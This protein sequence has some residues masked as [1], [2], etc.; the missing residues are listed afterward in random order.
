MKL[1]EIL[2]SLSVLAVLV[3]VPAL[4]AFQGQRAIASQTDGADATLTL[5]GVAKDGAWT[6]SK[7]NGTNYWWKSFDP[8]TL[9][10]QEGQ[11]VALRLQSTDVHHRFYAPSL[12]I[13]PVDVEPGHTEI[14]RFRA[15]KPGTY[16]YHCTSI[17]GETHFYMS[18]MIVVSPKGQQAEAVDEQVLAAVARYPRDL[19]EPPKENM[20]EW[21]RYLYEKNGCTTC[22]GKA[23][24]G[25]VKNF[26]YAKESIPAHNTLAEKFFLEEKE[27]ADAFVQL[28][29]KKVDFNKLEESVDIPKFQVV[30]TQYEAARDLIVKGKHCAKGDKIGPE[31]PLQM[32][33]W[34]EVLTDHDVDSIIAYLLTLYPWEDDEDWDE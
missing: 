5:Y 27:D 33:S 18:G 11:E 8:A 2:A 16:R 13:G 17:C 28:L 9:Y 10:F 6:L 1:K 22:H 26:N 25:G 32:P 21:G 34:R 12:G 3:A 19:Q 14:V 4:M 29:Q 7:V 30:L 20:I 31:P 23:G 15:N 24:Q